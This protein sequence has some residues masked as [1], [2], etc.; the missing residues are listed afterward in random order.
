MR[1]PVFIDSDMGW[2][3]LCALCFLGC[4][5][6]VE[7][8]GLAVHGCGVAYSDTAIDCAQKCLSMLSLSHVPIGTGLAKPLSYN[9]QYPKDF[10]DETYYFTKLLPPARAK[11]TLIPADTL[12]CDTLAQFPDLVYLSLG[13]FSNLCHA[14]R[15]HKTRALPKKIV[16]MGGAVHVAGNI[17]SLY[18]NF[19]HDNL[20]AEWNIFVDPV[21]A[22]EVMQTAAQHAIPLALVPLDICHQAP[23]SVQFV[24][25][26]LKARGTKP[27]LAFVQRFLQYWENYAAQKSSPE[28][29][30]DALAAWLVLSHPSQSTF[31]RGQLSIVSSSSSPPSELGKLLFT[32]DANSLSGYYQSCDAAQFHQDFIHTLSDK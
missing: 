10:R 28:Y 16:A 30:Y 7:I 4:H 31:C 20:S 14:L 9:H 15:R 26:I 19:S 11:T 24:D 5:P 23:L 3:D 27:A 22:N 8:V 12:L 29:L 6:A 2:D 21:A 18:P 1:L 32:P 17:P 25:T 13:G